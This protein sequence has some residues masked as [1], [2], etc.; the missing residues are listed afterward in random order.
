MTS[1]PKRRAERKSQMTQTR[2]ESSLRKPFTLASVTDR[3]HPLLTSHCSL[4]LCLVCSRSLGDQPSPNLDSFSC[5]TL[6]LP[7]KLFGRS[8]AGD[9]GPAGLFLESLTSDLFAGAQIRCSCILRKVFT[10]CL[11]EMQLAHCKPLSTLLLQSRAVQ[12][13]DYVADDKLDD[14]VEMLSEQD[15]EK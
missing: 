14:K 13:A 8:R 1:L 4:C 11:L 15:T 6:S 7:E 10:Q 12:A 3:N 9:G 5:T 2:S